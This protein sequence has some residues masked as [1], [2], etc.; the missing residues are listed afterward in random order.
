[1]SDADVIVA[2][3]GS[4]GCVLAARLSE[5]PSLRVLLIEAGP[6][7][8]GFLVNMPAGS[9]RLM[10]D[11]AKDWCYRTEPD[12]SIGGRTS[13]WSG[14]RMLGGSS[15]INGMVYIRGLKADYDD[16]V[17]AGARGWSWNEVLPYFL[18]S[19]RFEGAA[20]QSHGALGPLSVSP[21]RTRHP[22]ADIFLQA[23]EEAGVPAD[24]DYCAG[25]ASGG[26]AVL[27]TTGGG[28]RSST[29]KAFLEPALRRPNLQVLTE[30]LVERVVVEQGIAKGV[31]VRHGGETRTL[32]AA[33]EVIVSA[34]AIGSPTVLMRSGIGPPEGLRALGIPVRCPL[35]G[36]G[37]NLQEHSAIAVSKLVDM[38]TYNSPFGFA[39]IARNMIDYLLRKRGPMTSAAVQAMAYARSRPELE[40]PDIV[41]NFLPLAINFEGDRPGMHPQPGIS[42]A[43][44]VARPHSRGEIRLRSADPADPPII[45]HRLVGD[46]RDMRVLIEAGR[47][48]ARIYEA[49][50]LRSHVVGENIPSPLPS[51]DAEWTA[52]VR[53][54][55]SIGYHPTS[56]CSMGEGPDAVVD[57]ALRVRGV[58]ALRVID[59]SAMPNII[60]GNTNAPTIMIAERG[61]DLVKA[62]LARRAAA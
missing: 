21:G 30:R 36:V 54:S 37:R 46:E 61:A 58:G 22:L 12:E 44:N 35:T 5:D 8:G 1:M 55:A 16:W 11:P 28:Q 38:P 26:F 20:S 13:R 2:G 32:S 50:A 18:K 3:A 27:N 10:G 48:L 43:A 25:D 24:P 41:L 56:T 34:G 60:S 39:V 23:C 7:G 6:K 57:A 62:D 29:A 40:N 51:T 47:L 59:A 33:R 53:Q 9:F 19:E 15:A 45:D 14:G 42:V 31:V 49:P 17:R 4:A 52:Y